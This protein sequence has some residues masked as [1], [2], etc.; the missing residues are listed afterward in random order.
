TAPKEPP[1]DNRDDYVFMKKLNA[2]EPY[3]LLKC[4]KPWTLAIASFEGAT[5]LKDK[6][7]S[8]SFFDK[9]MGREG[10]ERLSAAA[11]NAHNLAKALHES[12][13]RLETYVLHTRYRSVV[14]VGGYDR[15]DDAKMSQD[16]LFVKRMEIDQSNPFF[17]QPR[18]MEV[19]H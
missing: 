8:G 3:S 14:S 7:S 1:P 5:L 9:L 19:P 17:I 18:P 6:D 15:P 11:M 4:G 2:D 12:K 10:G 16:A 13:L